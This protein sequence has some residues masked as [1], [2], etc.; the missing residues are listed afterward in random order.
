MIHHSEGLRLKGDGGR[1]TCR[2]DTS[3]PSRMR[4]SRTGGFD[5]VIKRAQRG[6]E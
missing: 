5:F 3:G 4:S 2:T 1:L 6:D